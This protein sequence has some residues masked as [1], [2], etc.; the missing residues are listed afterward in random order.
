MFQGD[1]MVR[2][3]VSSFSLL[4]LLAANLSATALFK[5]ARTYPSGGTGAGSVAAAALNGEGRP[6]I[7]VSNGFACGTCYYNGSV[8]VLLGKGDGTFKV[9]QTYDSGGSGA[10]G[11]AIP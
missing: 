3:V 2:S 4:L 7:V 8:A 6:D 1:S 10:G 5:P 9:A 11:I